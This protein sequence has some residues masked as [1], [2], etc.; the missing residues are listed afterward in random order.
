MAE[1]S[2]AK[3]ACWEMVTWRWQSSSNHA[4]TAKVD[5]EAEGVKNGGGTKIDR[6]PISEECC[7]LTW[8]RWNYLAL[9]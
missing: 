3:F 9:D 5:E 4:G 7:A 6:I 1:D 2:V 8:V